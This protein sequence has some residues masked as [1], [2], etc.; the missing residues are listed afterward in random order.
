MDRIWNKELLY[1]NMMLKFVLMG[2]ILD[3]CYGRFCLKEI[4]FFLD[5]LDDKFC[6][7]YF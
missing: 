3:N 4:V 2:V 6:F 5:I 1:Y 7:F